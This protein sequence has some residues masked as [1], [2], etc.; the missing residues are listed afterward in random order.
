MRTRVWH[1]RINTKSLVGGAA[2]SKLI[3]VVRELKFGTSR[4]VLDNQVGILQYPVGFLLICKLI[5]GSIPPSRKLWSSDVAELYMRMTQQ[6][7]GDFSSLVGSTAFDD[8]ERHMFKTEELE[9]LPVEWNGLATDPDMFDR[10]D[11]DSTAS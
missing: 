8:I 2:V 3:Y 11:E 6:S 9:I 5:S 4:T 1:L 7:A 10:S